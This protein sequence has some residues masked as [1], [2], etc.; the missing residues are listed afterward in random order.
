MRPQ[1]LNIPRVN[2]F[3]CVAENGV[4]NPFVMRLTEL[5]SQFR[6]P[7]APFEFR[8]ARIS[9]LAGNS[10]LRIAH[11]QPC[12]ED[13]LIRRFRPARMEFTD[14]LRR[15]GTMRSMILQQVFC[16]IFEVIEV[17]ILRKNSY[18]HGELPFVA[19]AVRFV[20]GRKSVRNLNFRQ[21]GGLLSFPR[22]GCA[23][24]RSA[25]LTTQVEQNRPM[26]FLSNNAPVAPAP[27]QP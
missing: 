9:I 27:R 16:L 2:Q 5:I 17:R 10:K 8:P 24:L 19:P 25:N 1:T 15:G 18:G 13:D 6:L 11:A 12:C 21:Q 26:A 23:L 4:F 14:A 20:P 22:T 7:D 3:Y